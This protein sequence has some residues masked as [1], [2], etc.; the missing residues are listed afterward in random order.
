MTAL[1]TRIP[2]LY[3]CGAT[4]GQPGHHLRPASEHDQHHRLPGLDE[5]L[6]ILLLPARQTQPH[7]VTVLAAQHHVLTHGGNDH[8]GLTGHPECL[9]LIG[10]LARLH[11]AVKDIPVPC[12]LVAVLA[13]FG[14]QLLGPVTAA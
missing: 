11:H 10:H 6:H 4:L 14:L 7:A 12:T 9:I 8:I 5:I 13:V 2:G 1:L 3:D